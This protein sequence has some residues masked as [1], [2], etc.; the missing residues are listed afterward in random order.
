MKKMFSLDAIVTFIDCHHAAEHLDEKKPD[1]VGILIF[2]VF[3][4]PP[5]WVSMIYY[6]I[7]NNF[8]LISYAQQLYSSQ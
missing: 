5:N 4:I 2:A 8:M 3:L 7:L 6:T 1:G